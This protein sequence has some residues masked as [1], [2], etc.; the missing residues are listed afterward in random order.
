M[1]K[2]ESWNRRILFVDDDKNILQAMQRNLRKVFSVSV[3]SSGQEGLEL[4]QKSEEFAVVISDMR[5]PGMDGAEFLS[6][7]KEITPHS[8][9][10]MLTGHADVGSAIAAIN[11]GNIFRFIV[12]PAEPRIMASSLR[13]AFEQ[14]RLV[15][16][17]HSL[18]EE[19]L[20]KSISVLVNMLSLTHPMAFS[21][22]MRVKEMVMQMVQLLHLEDGW[23]YE[24][25]AM[26]SQLGAVTVP[27]D[28]LQK[29]YEGVPLT[30][31]EESMIQEYPG[32]GSR[33]IMNIPRLEDVALMI[34]RMQHAA[35]GDVVSDDL[36][37]YSE[38]D[39]GAMILR[40]AIDYDLLLIR[41]F[42]R[43]Y[44]LIS[45][46]SE[47]G[48]YHPKIMSVLGRLKLENMKQTL[49]LVRVAELSNGMILGEDVRARTGMLIVTK[50]QV[51]SD[52]VRR[53]L[54]NNAIQGNISDT[55]RIVSE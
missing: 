25:A 37:G 7:V 27:T 21:Q 8:V 50:G 17:E 45:M 19:T 28:V 46:Q 4:I 30:K 16:A 5:M 35:T 29:Y 54:M 13:A 41:G 36:D 52:T 48:V 49:R 44:A 22:S 14:Y 1:V 10:I 39:L 51:V 43:S 11:N 2:T 20:K 12:K 40:T 33:L 18:I 3:A 53:C 31:D 34:S 24:I 32:A 42:D 9:R 23:K 15:D 47:R 55:L 26:L 6:K 38:E